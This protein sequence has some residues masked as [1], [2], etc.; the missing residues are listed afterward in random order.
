MAY[1][2]VFSDRAKRDLIDLLNDDS[3]RYSANERLNYVVDLEIR[4]RRLDLFPKR[5]TTE[6]IN[7]QEYWR[8]NHKAHVVF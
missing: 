7:G 4:A 5:G 6:W 8:L 3:G 1:R 2:V